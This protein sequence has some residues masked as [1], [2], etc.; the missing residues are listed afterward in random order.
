MLL[1]DV[2]NSKSAQRG[3]ENYRRGKGAYVTSG[4]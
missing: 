3:I 4:N 2:A 1:I